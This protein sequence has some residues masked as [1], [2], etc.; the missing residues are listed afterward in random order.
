[1]AM[2][3]SAPSGAPPKRK[4]PIQVPKPTQ[5]PQ[6]TQ[7]TAESSQA[8]AKRGFFARVSQG[9]GAIPGAVLQAG[10]RLSGATSRA[11]ATLRA[12]DPEDVKATVV[13]SEFSGPLRI[14]PG[15][16]R[17]EILE[18]WYGHPHNPARRRDLTA[19]AKRYVNSVNSLEM[20]THGTRWGTPAPEHF[21]QVL[22]VTYER[23][24][25]PPTPGELL[26]SQLAR[27]AVARATERASYEALKQVAGSPALGSWI[28]VTPIR[29][30]VPVPGGS[31]HAIYVSTAEFIFWS[32]KLGVRKASY[33][34]FIGEVGVSELQVMERP[35][36]E[37]AARSIVQK[38]R[39]LLPDRDGEGSST[40][41]PDTEF[42]DSKSF[43]EFCFG[44]GSGLD[45]KEVAKAAGVTGAAVLVAAHVDEAAALI[46]LPF[47]GPV[48]AAAVGTVG[49]LVV[50]PLLV[51]GIWKVQ[52]SND[53]RLGI[54]VIN[55]LHTDVSVG[56]FEI[57]DERRKDWGPFR[58][59]C[60]GLG[61]RSA[62][63][64]ASR[65]L[66]ELNPPSSS[67]VFQ[68]FASPFA[69]ASAKDKEK[70]QGE[71]PPQSL[72]A[73][74]ETAVE[75]SALQTVRRGR[76]YWILQ[77]D[78]VLLVRAVPKSLI[79]A[80]MGPDEFACSTRA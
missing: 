4:V 54:A 44:T 18:C 79:P 71:S 8:P 40:A 27:E 69:S 20:P 21:G 55:T 46:A 25:G 7:S 45:K 60:A 35:T 63:V 16:G 24:G 32:P 23:R 58:S 6:A 34:T 65:Q 17:L 47:L 29:M 68:L 50:S 9:L 10:D 11:V 28:C 33:L 56:T 41:S 2:A 61:G 14:K 43:A 67:E 15:A 1:M 39:S 64:A 37:S 26:R 31:V 42:S 66:L 19:E 13:C 62:G 5:T 38:A 80:Y 75:G 57:T 72:E 59:S 74:L 77:D 48:G 30:G 52:R 73:F 76:V 36:D 53:L 22:S 3:S 49:A 12:D 70:G 78:G 51:A